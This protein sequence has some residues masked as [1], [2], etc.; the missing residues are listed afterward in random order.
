[1]TCLYV[2]TLGAGLFRSHD[3]GI[4]WAQDPGIPADARLYSACPTG[5]GLLVGGDDAVYRRADHV[6]GRLG[7][8]GSNR[9]VWALAV[10]DGLIVGGTRPLGFVRSDD[11]GRSWSE[12]GFALPPGTPEPHTPRITCLLP[13]PGVPGELW[14]GVEVGG[15]FASPDAGRTWSPVNLSLSSLDIHALG[16]STGSVLLAATPE[17]VL[18]WRSGR[19]VVG[20]FEPTDRYCR[21]L[22]ASPHE[23]G[24]VFC[25][26]GDGPPGTRG[27]VAVSRDGG[28]SWRVPALPRGVDSTVW[29]VAASPDV[30][31]LVIACTISGRVLRSRDGG[32]RWEIVFTTPAAARAVACEST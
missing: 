24:T 23:A 28:R 30:P 5:D 27:G 19:W 32:A 14:A 12:P 8:P 16:W 25:G 6:W 17:G 31:G 15:V 26:F 22:A 11:G 10:M 21:A 9:T 18:A 13:T 2:G 3:L 20:A 7:L 1:M 29:S 4:T